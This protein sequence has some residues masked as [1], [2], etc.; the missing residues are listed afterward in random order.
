MTPEEIDNLNQTEAF[1]QAAQEVPGAY[2]RR[3]S[4]PEA[5]GSRNV[6][7]DHVREILPAVVSS[8]LEA[9]NIPE[10]HPH[11]GAIDYRYMTPKEKLVDLCR[12]YT[13]KMPQ[14]IGLAM[15]AMD[16]IR[17]AD[18]T[19]VLDSFAKDVGNKSLLAGF[20]AGGTTHFWTVPGSA[21]NFMQQTKTRFDGVGSLPEVAENGEVQQV[22]TSDSEVT[23]QLASYA[24]RYQLTDQ[25][26]ADVGS[27][28]IVNLVYEMGLAAARTVD[29]VA[30]AALTSGVTQTTPTTG[31]PAVGVLGEA[32]ALIGNAVD[33]NGGFL[34]SRARFMLV[35]PAEMVTA[36][37]LR[38][39]MYDPGPTG[40]TLMDII[41]EPR[42]TADAAW[43]TLA[44]PTVNPVVQVF[45]LG[46]SPI[47][48]IEQ[49]RDEFTMGGGAVAT[50]F[51]RVRIDVGAALLSTQAAIKTALA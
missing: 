11:P 34:N 31:S 5:Y 6:R 32:V 39:A 44:D 21:Q 41:P 14:N 48:A 16:G 47:P 50:K 24:N 45:G 37:T 43:Y 33:P 25:S 7:S 26:L 18:G 3:Q 1:R 36:A 2:G 8:F 35:P 40:L 27:D 22:V 9:S 13:G 12:A 28:G 29:N 17:A 23:Y 19:T 46:G 49:L 4:V 42:L 51:F 38:N 30:V 10:D 15:V 20:R